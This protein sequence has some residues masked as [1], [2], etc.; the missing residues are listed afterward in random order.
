MNKS[1]IYG[2]NAAAEIKSQQN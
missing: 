2:V 1:E